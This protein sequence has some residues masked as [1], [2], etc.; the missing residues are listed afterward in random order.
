MSLQAHDI[1]KSFLGKTVFKN[2]YAEFS[3]GIGFIFAPNGSG[4]TTL[5][6][7]LGGTDRAYAGKI[8]LGELDATKN[9]ETANRERA[10]LPSEPRFYPGV[11]AYEFLSFIAE[12]R[13]L[14]RPT[15]IRYA[16]E[17]FGITD[18]L[19]GKATENLSLG[20]K[21]RLFLSVTLLPELSYWILDEPTNGLDQ[22]YRKTLVKILKQGAIEGKTVILAS[23]D[24]SFA[25]ELG[26][27]PIHFGCDMLPIE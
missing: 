22:A 27:K 2:F 14:N 10:Y 15:L 4:K 5:L 7:I 12:V 20:Q 24:L 26:V 23:H 21:K 9:P 25:E 13:G 18:E 16:Q 19:L 6:N 8:T 11:S 3:P 1:S 17:R